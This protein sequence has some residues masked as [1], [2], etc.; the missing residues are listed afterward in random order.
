MIINGYVLENVDWKTRGGGGQCNTATKNGE[1]FFIK[2]LLAPKYPV[3]DKFDESFRRLKIKECEDWLKTRNKII[4][5]LPGTGSGN[6]VKPIEYFRDGPVYYEV[7][8]Y[9]DPAGLEVRN[10]HNESKIDLARLMLTISKTVSDVHAAGIIHAD[11]DSGNIIITKTTGGKLI[12]KVIDFTDSFFEDSIPD[13]IKSKEYWWSPEMALFTQGMR[14]KPNPFKKL[15]TTKTDV[16]SLGIVFHQYCSPKG[17]GPI[18]DT[19]QPWMSYQRKKAPRV[20]PSIDKDFAR[21]IEKMI[22]CEPSERPTMA[23]VHRELYEIVNGKGPIEE[24]YHQEQN[25]ID[26]D[27]HK[28]GLDNPYVPSDHLNGKGDHVT[29]ITVINQKKV[30]LHFSDSTTQIMDIRVALSIGYIKMK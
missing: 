5:V 1:L 16:F 27:A 20:D 25:K 9:I 22:R 19:L 23:E 14:Q 6:L 10:I 24:R 21:I 28:K 12:C 4:K 17:E 18:C 3:S 13:E 11:L 2:R 26:K 15:I 30:K 7:S 29:D 8:K